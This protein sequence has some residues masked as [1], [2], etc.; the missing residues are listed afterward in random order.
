MWVDMGPFPCR[1][2]S[3]LRHHTIQVKVLFQYDTEIAGLERYQK[4]LILQ[5][6]HGILGRLSAG[7]EHDTLNVCEGFEEIKSTILG[8]MLALNYVAAQ[9]SVLRSF[10]EIK[11][12][13]YDGLD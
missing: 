5:F 12:P 3:L 2:A 7:W 10:Q 4:H 11:V 8:H 1:L 6:M 13:Y 9:A